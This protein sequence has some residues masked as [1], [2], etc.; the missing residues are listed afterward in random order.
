VKI[1]RSI[2]PFDDDRLD[3][4]MEEIASFKKENEIFLEP[5]LSYTFDKLIIAIRKDN[6]GVNDRDGQDQLYENTKGELRFISVL[7]GGDINTIWHKK[8]L[9]VEIHGM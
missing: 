3:Y 4:E 2:E 5:V 7:E 9:D 6:V 1:F 8:V